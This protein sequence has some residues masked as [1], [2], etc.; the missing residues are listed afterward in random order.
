MDNVKKII[1]VFM[2]TNHYQKHA[3]KVFGLCYLG[4]FFLQG[5]LVNLWECGMHR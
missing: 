5:M 1:D 4:V 2:T 3:A